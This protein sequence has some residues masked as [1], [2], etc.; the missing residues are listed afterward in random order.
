[1]KRRGSRSRP[2]QIVGV[3]S[4]RDREVPRPAV[5]G[6]TSDDSVSVPVHVPASFD[7]FMETPS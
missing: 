6:Q 7:L 1:M 3:R 4:E 5:A 2:L